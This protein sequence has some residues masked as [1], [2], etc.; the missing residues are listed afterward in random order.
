MVYWT[1]NKHL[2]GC[3]HCLSCRCKPH[4]HRP[5]GSRGGF[6][7]HQ[8]QPNSF[9]SSKP[10]WLCQFSQQ[11]WFGMFVWFLTLLFFILHVS[12]SRSGWFSLKNMI[13]VNFYWADKNKK[14]ER[15]RNYYLKRLWPQVL[16]YLRLFFSPRMQCFSSM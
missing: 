13:Q 11:E 9:L 12:Y 15:G 16:W 7:L 1:F 3:T 2:H 5:G 10:F 14:G 8:A 6:G 4:S